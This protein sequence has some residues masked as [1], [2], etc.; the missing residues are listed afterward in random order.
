[1][2]GNGRQEERMALESGGAITAIVIKDSGI[3]E[4]S[5]ELVPK[6]TRIIFIRVNYL[7][8]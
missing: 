1:M 8:A 2:K 4:G 3:T 6:S 7:T 5:R